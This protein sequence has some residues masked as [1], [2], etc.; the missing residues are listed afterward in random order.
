MDIS[1]VIA[2]DEKDKVVSLWAGQTAHAEKGLAVFGDDAALKK[3]GLTG[4][5]QVIFVRGPMPVY[6]HR[7][8]D[9][10]PKETAPLET[11]DK[12]ATVLPKDDSGSASAKAA[13]DVAAG[14]AS[15]SAEAMADRENVFSEE[16][17]GK[18]K[19]K[20]S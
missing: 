16:K 15:A 9:F 2:V 1:A 14:E 19:G 5:V 6:S 3:E 12:P 4:L 20:R 10:R 11:R 7:M 13:E 18:G 17:A 8:A